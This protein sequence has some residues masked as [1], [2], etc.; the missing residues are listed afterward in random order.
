MG[1]YTEAYASYDHSDYTSVEPF[2]G[3]SF[4][5]H[6][7]GIIAAHEINTNYNSFM[8]SIALSELAALEQTG[9]TDVF[10]E[11]VD[12]KGIFAK[13]KA[14]FQKVLEKIRKI[15]HTFIAKMKSW[16]GDTKKFAEKYGKEIKNKWNDVKSDWEFK[17]YNFSIVGNITIDS[18]D[19]KADAKTNSNTLKQ[20]MATSDFAGLANRGYATIKNDSEYLDSTGQKKTND[21]WSDVKTTKIKSQGNGATVY[22]TPDSDTSFKDLKDAISSINENYED[23]VDHMRQQAITSITN[24]SGHKLLLKFELS[25]GDGLDAKEFSKELFKAFRDDEDSKKN[26]TKS[27]IETMYGGSINNLVEFIKNFDKTLKDVKEAQ[28]KIDDSYK[29]LISKI[30]SQASKLKSDTTGK[31]DNLTYCAG[32]YQKVYSSISSIVTEEFAAYIS[33]LKEKCTQAKEICVKTI[34]LSKKMTESYDYSDSYSDNGG[35]DFISS[36]KLV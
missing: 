26:I 14:F 25:T 12:I 9:S 7:L 1:I 6:E 24:S 3:E 22:D 35:F 20:L 18:N 29:K 21:D 19:I 15:F 8:K 36:V 23:C 33:A 4:N 2:I 32:F 5:Y 27:E 13:I 16:F 34:S 31:N 10:Y 17:G 11:S 28:K 30:E